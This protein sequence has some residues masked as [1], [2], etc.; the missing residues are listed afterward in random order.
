MT[1]EAALVALCRCFQRPDATPED[2][3][4]AVARIVDSETE[5][6]ACMQEI[7]SLAAFVGRHLEVAAGHWTA[8]G[9]LDCLNGA[10]GFRGNRDDYYD[11]RNSLLRHVLERRTGLPIMLSLLCMAIGRRLH[12]QVEGMG[13][14]GHFMARYQDNQGI[15]LLDP[16]YGTVVAPAEVEAHLEVALGKHVTLSPSAWAPVTPAQMALRILYNL[17]HAYLVHKEL[18][19]ATRVMDALI[20]VEPGVT[21]HWRERALLHHRQQQ[22]EQVQHDL[23]HYFVQ[24]GLTPQFTLPGHGRGQPAPLGKIAADDQVLLAIY[25]E[26]IDYVKQESTKNSEEGSGCETAK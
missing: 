21:Q 10:L 8:Q 26:S 25:R 9:L 17:R 20:A 22:W 16:Y 7:D 14:P 2:L 19:L 15:W 4:C 5:P 12:L 23:R 18:A 6:T 24:S 13:F 3:A 1:A 11:P